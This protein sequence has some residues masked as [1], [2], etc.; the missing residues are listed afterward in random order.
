ME[1]NL[2]NIDYSLAAAEEKKRRHDVMAHVHTFVVCCPKAAP[3]IHLGA[4]SCYV[5]DNT[6]SLKWETSPWKDKFIY[7]TSQRDNLCKCWCGETVANVM[8]QAQHRMAFSIIAQRMAMEG[9][10]VLFHSWILENSSI[11]CTLNSVSCIMNLK[12]KSSNLTLPCLSL[13]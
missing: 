8:L 13:N 5:G 12:G 4:T 3:I 10:L 6:V 11:T 1:A 7:W 2:K 9:I